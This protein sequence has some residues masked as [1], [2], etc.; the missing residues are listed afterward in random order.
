LTHI[1]QSGEQVIRLY[2][3]CSADHH[4]QTADQPSC[5]VKMESTHGVYPGSI[6]E[7]PK[8]RTDAWVEIEELVLAIPLVEAIIDVHYA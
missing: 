7:H 3:E 4:G 2:D 6:F 5:Q 1:T 8:V